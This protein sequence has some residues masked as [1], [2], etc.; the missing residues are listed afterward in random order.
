[1]YPTFRLGT[2]SKAVPQGRHLFRAGVRL[3]LAIKRLQAQSLDHQPRHLHL[4]RKGPS[5]RLGESLTAHD[6]SITII[7][8]T[9]AKT[10]FFYFSRLLGIRV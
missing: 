6:N 7:N 3:E 8:I 10:T 2:A 9:W 5:E 4:F 1:M